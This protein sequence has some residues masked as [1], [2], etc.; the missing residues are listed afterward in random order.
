[1][2]L[3]AGA[4]KIRL[5]LSRGERVVAM[6]RRGRGLFLTSDPVTVELLLLPT[7]QPV[8]SLRD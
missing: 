4:R 1:M 2:L 3:C 6:R 7:G 8:I 5:T